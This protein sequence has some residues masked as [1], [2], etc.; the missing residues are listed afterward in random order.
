ML[1]DADITNMADEEIKE[2]KDLGKILGLAFVVLD[3]VVVSIGAYLVY[4]S[5][6]GFKKPSVSN[7][8]LNKELIEFQAS[9]QNKPIVYT[10][11]TFN[12]NLE[13]IPRRFLRVQVNLEMLDEEGYEEVIDLGA[14]ARDS[15][16]KILNTKQFND[17]DSIQGKLHLKNQIIAQ[18]NSFLQRGVVKNVYFSEFVVQ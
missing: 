2:K 7:E 9:L 3:L 5:T 13:G 8:E 14:E 17:I 10:L 11:D 4:A 15:I 12:T 16:I 1:Q 18:I 6:L